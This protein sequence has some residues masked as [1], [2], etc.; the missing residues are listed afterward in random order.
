MGRHRVTPVE[1]VVPGRPRETRRPL[2]RVLARRVEP[3]VARVGQ[4]THLGPFA[5]RAGMLAGRASTSFQSVSTG[6]LKMR[7]GRRGRGP[8]ARRSVA[9]QPSPPPGRT[10]QPPPPAE[11]LRNRNV[12]AHREPVPTQEVS[13]RRPARVCRREWSE[14][15]P[16]SPT[17]VRVRG[18]LCTVAWRS[19]CS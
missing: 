7:P 5:T 13:L 9:R 6:K 4:G 16:G 15:G 3:R 17:R 1:A 19:Q 11:G 14:G 10:R 2:A 12:G 8:G 18:F